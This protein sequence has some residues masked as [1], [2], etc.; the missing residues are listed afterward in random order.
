MYKIG[1]FLQKLR[2]FCDES[3]NVRGRIENKGIVAAVLEMREKVSMFSKNDVYFVVISENAIN[4]L[5]CF[6]KMMRITW[7]F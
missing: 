4:F 3:Q 6:L 1:L 7:R 2:V 5:G